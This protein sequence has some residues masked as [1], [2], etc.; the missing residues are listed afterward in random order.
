[1]LNLPCCF[2][3][4]FG[5]ISG[6]VQT[7]S[8]SSSRVSWECFGI[9]KFFCSQKGSK[10]YT[11]HWK[12]LSRMIKY[13]YCGCS[14]LASLAYTLGRPPE[15]LKTSP[16]SSQK[17]NTFLNIFENLVSGSVPLFSGRAQLLSGCVQVISRCEQL[18]GDVLFGA[19]KRG[20]L[21]AQQMISK[22]GSRVG[23][24]TSDTRFAQSSKE[25][26]QESIDL[27][28]ESFPEASRKFSGS[29]SKPLLEPS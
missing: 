22:A 8:G 28:A 21:V 6:V 29:V 5:S 3:N 2:R 13:P 7:C 12:R 23:R 18:R 25:G 15:Q 9:P 4:C 20:P 26:V 24:T 14:V 16:F 17:W 19:L 1:M 11:L 27:F 10:V